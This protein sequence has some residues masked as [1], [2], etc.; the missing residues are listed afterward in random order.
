MSYKIIELEQGSP[1]W[2]SYRRTKITATDT[3]K[4]MNLSPFCTP[5]QL[6]EEKLGLR[7]STPI[8]D[9][10]REGSLMEEQARDF[11]NSLSE[12]NFKPIVLESIDFPFMM[13][14][15]DG[16]N[17][18]GDIVEIK[19][20][21]KSYE[22]LKEGKI[23]DYY[24]AQIQKQIYVSNSI[25]CKYFCYRSENEHMYNI[26]N[27]DDAFIE[28]MIE[29]EKQFYQCLL[30]FFPPPA[31]D[32]DFIKKDNDDW[33]K[34]TEIWKNTKRQIKIL[35][36]KEEALRHELIA[37]CD[38]QSS[39]GNG[40][41]ISKTIT[42]GRVDYSNIEALKEIDLEQYRGKNITSF[43]FTEMKEKDG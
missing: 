4:I 19:C 41:R 32:K 1:E 11:L 16:M 43:R 3:A 7:E 29:A 33:Y 21:K 24:Y 6:W 15:L 20:G 18:V 38:G 22:D 42:K 13:A 35:E 23:P 27:R 26:I 28:K 10:M 31:T 30:N 14:S 8:N 34:H 37:M 39:Q 2:L 5:L 17:S 40:V 36:A 9:K 12:T 25:C